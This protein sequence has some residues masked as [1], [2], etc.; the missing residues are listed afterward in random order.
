MLSRFW[1]SDSCL[2]RQR[3]ARGTT[4]AK[5]RVLKFRGAFGLVILDRSFRREAVGL[6]SFHR[7]SR[8]L[9]ERDTKYNQTL[10]PD[11]SRGACAGCSGGHLL[12]AF[13]DEIAGVFS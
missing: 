7:V 11:V 10:Y 6:T 9:T 2:E 3:F 5:A 1:A 8:S 12:D 4:A 13:P